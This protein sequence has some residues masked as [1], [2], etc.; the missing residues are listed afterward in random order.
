MVAA[1]SQIKKRFL[2][3]LLGRGGPVIQIVKKDMTVLR[4]DRLQC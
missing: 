1:S 2:I 4:Y 3:Q